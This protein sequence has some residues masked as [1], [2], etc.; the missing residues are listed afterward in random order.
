MKNVLL[1]VFFIVVCG[2]AEKPMFDNEGD[3]QFDNKADKQFDVEVDK[4]KDKDT[5]AESLKLGARAG[6][7]LDKYSPELAVNE[8][9][10]E[11]YGYGFGVGLVVNVPLTNTLSFVSEVGFFYRKQGLGQI[12]LTHY[13]TTYYHHHFGPEDDDP[14]Y[15]SDPDDYYDFWE[16]NI[17]ERNE[18]VHGSL[19][20]YAISIPAMLRFTPGKGTRFAMPFYL[21]V[22]VQ[23]D[24]P[25][26]S[27][28]IYE[29][30]WK[31]SPNDV[32]NIRAS[33][34]FGIPLGFGYFITPNLEIDLRA[35][36]GLTSTGLTS[37][38]FPSFETKDKWNHYGAGLTYYF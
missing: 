9:D 18:I 36:I 27:E 33:L 34:D 38:T 24:I 5:N 37:I 16:E 6:F 7:S 23:L 29:E 30:F 35:V 20:E 13:D 26:K 25:I 32:S 14:D 31:N 17:L 22:G 12:N 11:I 21:A 19:H 10:M 1:F 15:P 4:N 8:S 3:K 28:I 2:Y